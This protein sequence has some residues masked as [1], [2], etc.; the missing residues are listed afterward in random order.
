[1]AGL[2]RESLGRYEILGVIGA[3][4]MGEIY[5]ARDSQLGREV[6]VKVIRADTAARRT[7]VERF[8]REAR[9]VALLSHPN[10]LDIHDFDEDD[11]IVY[12][13]TELLEGQDLRRRL[14]HG[15]LP[16]S[17]ALKVGA[18]VADGLAAAHENG[19]VHRDIKPENV[20]VTSDG[21]VK[22]LDFG[23]A[24]LWDAPAEGSPDTQA[25][26][27]T[28]TESGRVLGT[29][30]YLSPEQARG[31]TA[32]A[33]SDIFSLGCLLY[34]MLTGKRAFAA[35]T[36]QKT[37]LAVLN[38]DPTPMAEFN[39]N[40]PSLLD[41]IVMRCL[42]KQ[43]DE[44]FQSARDV[45]FALEAVTLNGKTSP[46]RA[47]TD[48]RQSRRNRLAAAAA[49]VVAL[50]AATFAAVQ[51]GRHPPPALPAEKHVSVFRIK[52]VADDPELQE[53]A[54]GLT[55]TVTLGLRRIEEDSRAAFWVVPRDMTR[56]SDADTV[57]KAYRK[58][59]ITLGVK[60]LIERSG[61]WIALGFHA[62]DPA[63]GGVLA[64][65]ELGDDLSNL[66]SF[67]Q[68]SIHRV[69]ELLGLESAVV[70]GGV[71]T[72][73]TNISEALRM[74][75]RGRG[76]LRQAQDRESAES[77]AAL[78][79]GAVRRDPLFSAAKVALAEARLRLFEI[80]RDDAD[81]QLALEAV[82]DLP[83]TD[84]YRGAAHRVAGALYRAAGLLEEAETEY[85]RAVEV[86][87]A[88][89][90]LRID[91][92]RTMLARSQTEQAREQFH[93]A[94][95]LRPGYWPGNHWLASL[96]YAQGDYEA[97]AI[98]FRN[99]VE[100]APESFFGYNNLAAV[101][102]KLGLEEEAF[103]ALERSIEVGPENNSYALLN[104]G[105]L[106]FDAARFADAAR[107]FEGAIE[108]DAGNYLTWGNLA[109]AYASGADPSRTE[110]AA[111]RAIE[112]GE[113]ELAR[114]PQNAELL[115]HLAGYHALVGDRDE[116]MRL[117][118]RAIAT[119]PQDPHVIGNI[120]GTWED[121]G[122]RD[123]ALEWVGR[124]FAAGVL[125][126]RFENRPLLRGLVADERYATLV[127]RRDTE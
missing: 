107:S 33:R 98:E 52:A 31:E 56:K 51:L 23:I 93:K 28:L 8:E 86:R 37:M 119:E 92:G 111:R 88:D 63:S 59:N 72:G 65:V 18:A 66:V 27:T 47:A 35:E 14:R 29:A 73:G 77:A 97:A 41:T 62:V 61:D 11:G 76:R 116:G 45:T 69:A 17:T 100:F 90:E 127:E 99:V 57:E 82:P 22:I 34:E 60:G 44:R 4:G 117:I 124:A 108:I 113:A 114:D 89:A 26:T 2:E 10:I 24:G 1:M 81:F 3:G 126:S 103:E 120:A 64:S 68:E 58:F 74:F 105:K 118:H 25:R 75:L 104:L 13:V 32:D 39:K 5:R 101:Y 91:L 80:T 53:I 40:L 55:E 21:R 79:A 6:A 12:A 49:A 36:P 121:L 30:G 102:D 42:E 96:N 106:Y 85:R 7:A 38:R 87:P 71:F 50:A 125:P 15:K 70:P 43:P 78:L 123:L 84:P 48:L 122:E 9:T 19:I 20:F 46:Y 16:L 112:L 54:D 95:F 115:C 67:Q 94:I 109:Y 83:A 110:D